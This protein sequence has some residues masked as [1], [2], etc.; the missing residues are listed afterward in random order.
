MKFCK[1]FRLDEQTSGTGL[2][3][4]IVKDIV[5]VYKGKVWLEKSK[6]LGVF[7]LT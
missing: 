3:L 6:I 4:N 5:E 1:G 2:D 7:K